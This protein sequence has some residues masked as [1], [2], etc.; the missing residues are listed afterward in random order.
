MSMSGAEV[1]II[2][3]AARSSRMRRRKAAGGSP[4]T[5]LIIRSKWNREKCSRSA[6]SSPVASWSS[7]TSARVSTK[8]TNV[9]R[10]IV[11]VAMS[12]IVLGASRAAA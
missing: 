8:L 6:S 7:S 5:D 11:I 3:Y 10:A 4:A 9:S 2:R 12:S 1:V